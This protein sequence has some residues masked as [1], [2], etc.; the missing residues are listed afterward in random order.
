MVVL[1]TEDSKSSWGDLAATTSSAQWYWG[2]KIEDW[3]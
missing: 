1:A 3:C 2:N